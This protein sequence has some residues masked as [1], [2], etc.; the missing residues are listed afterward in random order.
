PEQRACRPATARSDQYS[1]CTSL[2]EALFGATDAPARGAPRWLVRALEIG[3]AEDPAARHPSMQVLAARLARTPIRRRRTAIGAGRARAAGAAATLAAWPHER[4]VDCA[5]A[6]AEI[7]DAWTAA[8]R[9]AVTAAFRPAR[10]GGADTAER[11][12]AA[13]DDYVR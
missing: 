7:G 5:L 2:W 8:D 13:L 11:V 12:A 4:G 10:A 9:V 6:G 3:R 1:F